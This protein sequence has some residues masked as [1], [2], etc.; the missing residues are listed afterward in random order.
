MTTAPGLT[1]I[2]RNVMASLDEANV[3]D[4]LRQVAFA[5]AFDLI[6][7]VPVALPGSP[8]PALLV[9]PPAG[10]SGDGRGDAIGGIATRLGI[11]PLQAG[12]VFDVD[13]E[14]VH[15]TVSP[16]AFNAKK[17]FAMQEVIRVM[18]AARQALE[19]EEFTPTSELRRVCEDRGVLD[20]GNFSSALSG[21]DGDGLRL[22]GSGA[23]REVKLNARGFEKAGEVAKRLAEPS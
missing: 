20:S 14:G 19:L 18:S 10:G 12:Q 15:L 7:G 23:A 21:L 1:D 17:R 16:S 8:P 9:N 13:G 11:T 3:P 6:A 4:D 2:L 5:K 22:R